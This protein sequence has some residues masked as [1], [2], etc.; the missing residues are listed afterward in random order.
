MN[1]LLYCRNPVS[2][3]DEEVHYN[4]FNFSAGEVQ[5]RIPETPKGSH[6]TIHLCFPT[7][8]NIMQTVM[9]LNA[10]NTQDPGR[11][12]VKL[13]LPYL[14]YSRQDRVCYPGEANSL[15]VFLVLLTYQLR[16][17]DEVVTWDVHSDKSSD[18][19]KLWPQPQFTNVTVDHLL[20]MFQDRGLMNYGSDTDL[21][22]I[23]PDKGAAERALKGAK[24]L[25]CTNI[26][27][28][29]KIRN[30][31]DGSIVGIE[32]LDS[33]GNPLQ[34]LR[35]PM[36]SLKPLTGKRVL[37]ID[38]I[39]DGGRTFIELAKILKFQLGASEVELYV[40]HGIFSKGF[41]VF[42]H[43]DTLLVD[44]IYTA[45]LFPGVQVPQPSAFTPKVHFLNPQ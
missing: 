18:F 10:I 33:S 12:G 26:L 4:C 44:T 16:L 17:N 45:N 6:Y 27:C 41:E 42:S 14:P 9:L 5:V 15:Q 19:F 31:L 13:F 29:E 39:C 25:G 7:S 2:C 22:V 3:R 21:V 11:Q 34:A 43:N 28:A 8:E 23:S 30:P 32:V 36:R 38:D 24:V 20:P 37:I 35:R 1:P 40:T